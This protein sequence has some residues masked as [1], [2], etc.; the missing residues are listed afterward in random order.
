M[1]KT[2]CIHKWYVVSVD[3]HEH[4]KGIREKLYFIGMKCRCKYCS[5][6]KF[7]FGRNINENS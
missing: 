6:E 4:Q 5:K 3:L 7:R 1:L 2:I